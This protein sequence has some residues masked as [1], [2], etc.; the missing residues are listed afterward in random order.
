[1]AGPV[2]SPVVDAVMLKI[3]APITTATPNTTRSNQVN[4]LRSR[5][6]GSS[7]SAIDCST[8]FV[9][10]RFAITPP[11]RDPLDRTVL[12]ADMPDNGTRSRDHAVVIGGSIGGLCAAR[13]LSDCYS[14]VTVYERDELPSAPANRATVPQ[15]RH[16]HMLMARAAR[17]FD[18]LFPGLLKDMVAA[19]VPMLENRPDCIHFGAA[20][21]VLGVGQT[22][23]DEFTAYVPSRP[24]L[25]WQ[26]RKR[27]QDIDNVEIVRH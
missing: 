4:S 6:S 5:V 2:M 9:R 12:S 23:R 26:L 15:D 14:R 3:P 17:E 8:D 21:H 18:S 1:M 16:L 7:V 22:L 20:G 27:V 11:F 24:H 13:V 19:G 25:E 10:H